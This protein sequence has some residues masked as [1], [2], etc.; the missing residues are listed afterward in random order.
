MKQAL[1]LVARALG[2]FALCRWWTRD[3]LRILC[4]HGIWIGP[5]PHYGDRLYMSAARFAAR[6]ALIDRLGYRVIGLDEALQRHGQGRNR[7]RELV[8]TIDDAWLGTYRHMLPE[9]ERRGFPSTLYVTTYYV[10]TQRPVLN[11]LLGYLASRP[12]GAAW[13]QKLVP[14]EVPPGQRLSHLV[15]AVDA[16]PTLDERWREVQRIAALLPDAPPIDTLA[17]AFSLMAPE[18]LQDAARRG[19]DIQLH[20]HTH[21]MHGQVPERVAAEIALNRQRLAVILNRPHEQLRHFCYPSGEHD[22]RVFDAVARS[23]VASATTTEFGLV[24]PSAHPLA[25]RRILDGETVSDIEFEA[26]L[27][28]CWSALT[29]LRHGLRAQRQPRPVGA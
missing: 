12:G 2:L 26:M 11:V 16:L 29:A 7:A 20:T 18:Q 4:Y 8:I 5:P 23:G 19:M 15:Q 21:R 6:M 25:L 28:G 1:L 22:P 3:Q 9:L 17:T 27:S 14:P 13:L 10:E 24:G